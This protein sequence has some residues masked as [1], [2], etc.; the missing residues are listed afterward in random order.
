MVRFEAY[1]ICPV[2]PIGVE[3]ITAGDGAI[4][5]LTKVPVASGAGVSV[6]VGTLV[7][8]TAVNVTVAV[9]V[10]VM[11]AVMVAVGGEV[12]VAVGVAVAIRVGAR[13]GNISRTSAGKMPGI[14]K[15][16]PSTNRN[17]M[18]IIKRN[19]ATRRLRSRSFCFLKGDTKGFS[20][21]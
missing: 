5:E 3:D 12:G 11:V 17:N 21:T 16:T 15:G 8:G 1:A 19:S 4:V 10:A 6:S 9:R 2:P 7:G 14:R 20:S 13:K 18:I